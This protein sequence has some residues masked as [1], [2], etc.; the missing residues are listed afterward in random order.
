GNPPDKPKAPEVEFFKK[1]VLREEV[2][3]YRQPNHGGLKA[4]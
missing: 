4:C 1:E 2:K 3:I